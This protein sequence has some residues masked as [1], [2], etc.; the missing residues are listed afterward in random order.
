MDPITILVGLVFG[1]IWYFNRKK[2]Q[3]KKGNNYQ[4]DTNNEVKGEQAKKAE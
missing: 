2:E 4:L 1:L 3:E